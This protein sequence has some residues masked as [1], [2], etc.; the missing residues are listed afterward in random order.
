MN[1]AVTLLAGLV[2]GA[3]VALAVVTSP[4]PVSCYEIVSIRPEQHAVVL[5]NACT[6]DVEVRFLALPPASNLAPQKV[7]Q[8]F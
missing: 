8:S 3:L 2:V 1:N 6:G 4:S 5:F 7:P